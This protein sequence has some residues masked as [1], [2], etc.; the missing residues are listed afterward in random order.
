MIATIK[1][2]IALSRARA[3]ARALRGARHPM[4]D[5]N[6]I[7]HAAASLGV[8]LAPK[9]FEGDEVGRFGAS[10]DAGSRTV[11][12]NLAIPVRRRIVLIARQL[13]HAAL[14]AGPAAAGKLRMAQRC[15]MNGDGTPYAY[16]DHEKEAQAFADELLAPRAEVIGLREVLPASQVSDAFAVTADVIVRQWR[17]APAYA[18]SS[19]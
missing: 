11:T 3:A 7:A 14:H 19:I 2:A 13:G 1:T 5:T 17:S 9:T 18:V 16:T 6:I 12:Y 8:A 4:D 10:Y 15:E